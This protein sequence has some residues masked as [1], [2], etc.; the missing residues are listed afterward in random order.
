MIPSLRRLAQALLY[1]IYS[2]LS[3][4][5]SLSL[6][7]VCLPVPFAVETC[8]RWGQQTIDLLHK[9]ARRRAPPPAC[10]EEDR[11]SFMRIS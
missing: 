10:C 1:H 2:S 9:L 3:L 11:A 4:P 7:V 8:G 6:R 5:L